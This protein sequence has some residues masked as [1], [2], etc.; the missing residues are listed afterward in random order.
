MSHQNIICKHVSTQY[1]LNLIS[2]NFKGDAWM[3]E[4]LANH[5]LSISRKDGPI[6]ALKLGL[7]VMHASYY[8]RVDVWLPELQFGQ[9]CMPSCPCCKS[10]HRVSPH[11]FHRSHF[12]RLIIHQKDN[13]FI[14]GRRYICKKC[15]ED[16]EQSKISFQRQV[17]KLKAQAE[18][19]MIKARSQ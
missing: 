8:T 16:N 18:S 19:M 2:Q 17:A 3:L 15:Q 4:W 9:N 7:V 13:Y 11:G 5:H 14:I 10:N 6:I 1:M 12:G